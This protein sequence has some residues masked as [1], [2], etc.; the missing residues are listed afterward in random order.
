MDPETVTGGSW[1][2]TGAGS[3][4]TS[5]VIVSCS[6]RLP[7]LPVTVSGYVPGAAVADTISCSVLPEKLLV[8]PWGSPEIL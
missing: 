5:K 3:L 8:T 2:L 7:D 6:L 4:V 1:P